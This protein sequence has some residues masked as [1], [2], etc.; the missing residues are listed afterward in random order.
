MGQRL[1]ISVNLH[2]KNIAKIYYH[3]SAY[4]ESALREVSDVVNCIYGT[5]EKEVQ[6]ALIRMCE[7]NGGG[8]DHDDLEYARQ[9]FPGKTFNESV[10]RSYGLVALSKSNMVAMQR[11]SEGDVEVNIDE[12]EILNSVFFCFDN[13]AEYVQY[14]TEDCGCEKDD[15]PKLEEIPV[16]TYDLSTI[17]FANIDLIAN[18]L[19][20]ESVV[21][22]D[23]MIYELIC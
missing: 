12:N 1:V 14:M 13:Y 10:D 8:V 2:G 9:L 6:F 4:T 18:E 22:F 23:G 20:G 16:L 17:D 3:W 19:Q 11:W 21:Q 7:R 15:L 5:T